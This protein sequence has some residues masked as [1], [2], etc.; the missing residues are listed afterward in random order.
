MIIECGGVI[1]DQVAY[2]FPP[3]PP[4]TQAS[5]TLKPGFLDAVS[6]DN[7]ANWCAAATSSYTD[8]LGNTAFGTPG[9]ANSC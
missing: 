2:T 1:I 5:M 3:Y 6:N 4:A 9:T 7:G 8:Q